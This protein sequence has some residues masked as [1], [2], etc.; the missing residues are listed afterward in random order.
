MKI[1]LALLLVILT[2]FLA[3]VPAG[4][5]QE[6]DLKIIYNLS[7][8]LQSLENK[9]LAITFSDDMLPL[10]GKRDGAAIVLITPAVKGEFT[11]R[12]NRTLAFK[13]ETRFRYSTTYTATIPAGTKSLSGITLRQ[14]LRWQWNTPLA[15]PV[16]VKTA[17][18]NY[19]SQL[20]HGNKLGFQ[21]WVKDA[22]TLRFNQPVSAA[23][24]KNFVVLKEAKS[25]IQAR[26]QVVQK[27]SDELEIQYP[28]PLKRGMEYQLIVKKGFSGS[29]GGT[30]TIKDYTIMFATV[31]AFQYAGKQELVLFPDSPY[32]WLPF[33]NPLAEMD[34]ALIKIYKISGKERTPLMFRLE[35]RHYENQALFITVDDKLAS[36]D[37][38]NI[39]ID[40]SLIN[41][42]SERLPESLELEAHVCSS[43]SPRLDFSMQGK[44]LSM[45]AKSMKQVSVRLLKLKPEFYTQL[46]NRD[47]GMLQQRNFKADFIEKEILQNFTGLP[48][49]LNSPALRDQELGSPLGFFGVLVQR[50][51]PYNACRDIAL[52]RLPAYTSQNLQVFHRRN[53]DMV[54]KASQGQ[55]LYWLYDNQT[56]KGLGKIPFFLKENGKETQPLGESAANGV[57]L[58]DR[59]I[60]ESN[61]IL[62]KNEKDGDMALAMIDR[63]PASDREV[64]ISVFSERDF[65]KPGDTVH[66]A[67]IVKEY[68]SGK[69]SSPKATTAALEIT[70]PD[71]QQVKTDTLQLDRLGGFHYEFKSDPAGKKGHHQIMVKI[72]DTQSWQGQHSITIDYYQP[73]TFELTVSGV[74]KHYL[75]TDIFHPEVSGSYLA[76]NP[77]AGDKVTYSLVPTRSDGRVFTSGGLERFAFGLDSELAQDDP[78]ENGNKK[79]DS[80]GK[81]TLGIPM[82]TFKKTNY[83]ADLNFSVTGKSAEGKE[84][85]TR[86]LSLFFP[87][88]LLTGIHIGYY[89][90]LKEPV[91]AELALVDFKGTPTAG[92]ICVSLYQMFYEDHN[93]KLKKVAGPEDIYID[94]T[95]THSFRVQKTGRYVLRCDTP[96]ANGRVVSTSGSFFAWDSGYS[97]QDNRLRIETNKMILNTGETLKCFIR[98]PHEGQALV[99]IERE[100]VLDSRIIKLQKMTPLEIP[101]KKEYF[102]RIRV[103]IIAMYEN[104][105]SEETSTEFQVKD[106]G[107][108]LGIDLENPAE[109]KPASKTKLKIKVSDDKKRGVK[110]KLFVY[111]VDESNLS[112]QRYLTPDPH[113]FFYYSN[114]LSRNAIW[115]YYSRNYFHWTFER[116]M[117]DISL[118]E[119]AIFG[120]VFSPDST[121]L[122]GATV[123]LEDEKHNTLK[124]ATTSAQGYYSFPGLPS[125]RYAVKAEA[126]GFHPFLQS[127]IY[128]DGGN[129]RPCDLALIPVSADK[130]WDAAGDF[131]PEGGITGG[132]MPAPMAAEMKSMARQ[133]G[134]GAA[135]DAAVGGVLGEVWT[136]D[137][138]NVDIAGIR[139]RSDFKE[140]LFFKTVE[141]DEAGNATI[142]FTSSDQLSTYRIMAVAYSE[143]SF[144]ATEKKLMV[145]KDLLIS[146]AMPEFARQDDEFSAGVQLS[147][148]TAQKLPV[149][150]L[151]KPEGIRIKGNPQIERSLD[152]RGNSL[153]QFPFLADRIGE[154]TIDFYA[155]SA[156]DKD[157]LQKKLPVTDRLVRET[158]LDFASG[159]TVKKMIEPQTDVENQSINIKVAPSLLRPTVN[160]AKKLVF[161][162]YE[163]LEQRASKVMPFLALSPQLADRLELGLDQ[164]QIREA[165]N[166]YLKIIPEFM[167]SAGALSYYRGGQYTSDYL[168]AYVLW[169]LYLAEK[170]DFKIDPQLVQKLSVYLQ[171]A[172]LDKTTEA[173][174][175]FVLSLDKRA[176]NKKLKKM[177]A[178]RDAIPLSSRVFLYR[179][180]HNQSGT[181]GQMQ[182]LLAEFNNSLQVEADF[183][184]FDVREFSYNRDFPFYSSRFATALLL[185]AILEVEHGYVL[186]EKII[187]WLLEGEPYCWNTTQTNFWI[188]CAMD[189]YLAQ[190]EKTTARKAEITLLG[191]KTA[192]EFLNSRDTLQASKKLAGRKDVAEVS[193]T[194]DQPV[195]VTSELTYQLARAGKKSRG[196][197]VRRVIYDEKG[198]AVESFKRGQIYQVELLVRTDKEIPYGVIDEPLA[199]G[200][201]L[202]RQD[203]G[204][205]RSLQEFNTA[206]QR[207]YST[208]WARQENAA[209]R[210]VFYTYSMQGSLRIVYFVKAMYSGRFTWLPTVA[211][212][213]YHP[214][215]F[216]RNEMKTVE[217]NE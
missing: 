120:C 23:A 191:E 91:K 212:G 7:G 21:V 78:P 110:A 38:L 60:Q 66:I 187:N 11:W 10:G 80:R 76:G 183:A 202:L 104:N 206:N 90:N 176:D 190:V 55:T 54:V 166:G 181:A 151:A 16:E 24:A 131:G 217:V 25:G 175:Q 70:G 160:I 135:E 214:Q 118:M 35:L 128:F 12:G 145:S 63:R 27:T 97:D 6:E 109:I 102:P 52:M 4:S 172:D 87:G 34:P 100:K 188:L 147:N 199:A 71:W 14:A 18:Q 195:Y 112:L 156:V 17:D 57:L 122:A 28:Q 139:V 40:R 19:F 59:E 146:E 79:L 189:E 124:T 49:K 186:A 193:V 213:M 96:D 152:P 169:S 210:L 3:T 50:Y 161:Y 192:K 123:T 162:P 204:T 32:C 45:S 33:S 180:L 82:N 114:P 170:R 64:R 68:T 36:G 107:R 140:V 216:G 86:V 75:F 106:E 209:D 39:R 127:D 142:D 173:F 182:T 159:K 81:Y 88:N 179:A 155:V 51:E 20:F 108:T 174:Y 138:V 8:I 119:P 207:K 2:T 105:L 47:F 37:R 211:Q 150:L 149:T 157:G 101:V 48:E 69:I 137:G 163:C 205:T 167:N 93:W 215:Y 129:H 98:S 148:R 196:I 85:T 141:T 177:Y 171:R 89:Q 94:K 165:V 134:E 116:P 158:L 92:E 22:I 197:D 83:L 5:P 15:T 84:F 42:Y 62:A 65:Y 74:E 111:A 168:T 117:M 31:P 61:L 58:S 178:E 132:A 130:Y 99:T 67:G 53:M 1:L 113:R 13:P 30:G 200:F 133:K 185:Q 153:F 208:P 73:N 77:M 72:V 103:S 46:T 43:R 136:I 143:D 144:G 9:E 154:A 95:K 44:K 26:S 41:I 201:E 125:G 115:T 198:Q 184:Y 29:E 194:A 121:P 126:K 203:I 164:G 56:G